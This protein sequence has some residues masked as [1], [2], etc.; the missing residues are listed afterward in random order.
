MIN[1]NNSIGAEQGLRI[2]GLQGPHQGGRPHRHERPEGASFSQVLGTAQAD[3]FRPPHEP[4][5]MPAEHLAAL[6]DETKAA[7]E[8][9][10]A[11][12]ERPSLELRQQIRAELDA[13]GIERPEHL[14]RGAETREAKREAIEAQLA[15]IMPEELLTQLQTALA[16]GDRETLESLREELQPYLQEARN[17]LS[18]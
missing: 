15:E 16:N 1:F 4:K 6:S 14:P 5:E 18:A 13:A 17:S 9:A 2:G 3:Q 7:L 12:G 10:K 8:T 11:N